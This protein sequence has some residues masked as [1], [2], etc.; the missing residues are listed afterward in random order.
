MASKIINIM[1]VDSHT[2]VR[3]GLKALIEGDKELKVIATSENGKEAVEKARELNPN[4]II[5]DIDIP[6]MSGIEVLKI[7]KDQG[8][9][10]KVIILTALRNREFIIAATKLGAM[11]YLF[12]NCDTNTLLKSI[13]EISIGRTY[14]DQAV[15]TVLTQNVHNKIQKSNIELEKIKSLSRR[16]YEVLTLISSGRSNKDIGKELFISEKTVKNHITKLFKKIDVND[17][18][19]ATIFAYQNGII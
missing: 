14:I 17:R 12:K 6:Y 4:I 10:S 8:L 15:A 7:I 11:G 19:Q 2:I 3:E 18:V 9:N 16:E 13:R 5:M 1:L